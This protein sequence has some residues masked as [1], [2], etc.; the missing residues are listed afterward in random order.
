M[1]PALTRPRL[2]AAFWCWAAILFTGTHWP[3]LEIPGEGRPDLLVHLSIFGLWGS[4]L[5]A[6]GFFGR[7]TSWRNIGA[8][9]VIGLVYGAIDELLQA[10]PFIHRTCALD[11]WALDSVGILIACTGGVVSRWPHV[12][13]PIARWGAAPLVGAAVAWG[14]A[15][16]LLPDLDHGSPTVAPWLLAP[17]V[18]LLAS[19][20]LMPFIHTRLWHDHYPKFALALGA[21]TASYYLSAYTMPAPQG[22]LSHGQDQILHA[23]REYYSFIALVGGLFVVSGGILL[24]LR[25]RATPLRNTLL[26][27]AGSLLAN[28]VGT[29]GASMLLIR[30]FMRINRGRLR[31][32]HIVF[33]IFIISNT[34]GS[35][36]PIGDPPLYLGFLKGVPFFWTT[37]HLLGDWAFTVGLLLALFAFLDWRIGPATR[38]TGTPT[39]TDPRA[40]HLIAQELH[41]LPGLHIRGPI[42]ITA[43]ILM[44]AGVFID[45]LIE[46]LTGYHGFPIGATFQLAVAAASYRLA[47]REILRENDFSFAPVKEVAVL[48]LGIFLTM[49]P[50]LAYLSAHG[51][52]LGIHSPTAFY[53]G[54][55][56]L[57]AFL[58]NAPT[59]LNFLQVALPG[60]MTPDAVRDFI[61]THR[62]AITLDAIST[63]A[64]FFGAMTYIGNGPN[65]MV[66]SI[67]E[68][69]GV[70]MPSFL[71]YLARAGLFLL[72][73]LLLHWLLFIYW[74]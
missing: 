6:A 64:V 54:T 11:D 16:F 29:T 7:P 30:P 53:F 65:F 47:P 49:S 32:L 24:D 45:P 73:I 48:F 17:F 38:E 15:R 26:L 71:G 57:S 33:F 4:L 51:D 19:I 5:I 27:A 56:I 37:A 10:I 62:G 22:P 46:R 44:I 1:I 69:A 21:F 67:A 60:A 3:K 18:L 20:A 13:R 8:V 70:R 40:E 35:L 66:K 43:L 52:A 72:P 55:G 39:T 63:A 36:T 41:A 14:L 50:A 68:S 58:D 2:R 42:G 12:A 23:L 9:F 61:A 31:S 74:A 28:L 59:Y 25:G 34:A